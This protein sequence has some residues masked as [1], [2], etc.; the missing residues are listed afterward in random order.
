MNFFRRFID[1]FLCCH[2]W[3]FYFERKHTNDMGYVYFKS[4]FICEKCG[5][6]KQIKI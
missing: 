4:T 3:K 5:K 2:K 1:K 6:F